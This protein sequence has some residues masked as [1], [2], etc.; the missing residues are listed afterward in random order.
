MLTRVDAAT[1]PWPA[2]SRCRATDIGTSRS[3]AAAG[4]LASRISEACAIPCSRSRS[5]EGGRAVIT[6]RPLW[7]SVSCRPV[8]IRVN[9]DGRAQHQ[10]AYG[11]DGVRRR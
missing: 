5:C 9:S 2:S 8:V 10:A 11:G 7:A 4:R 3:G 1:G 6:R